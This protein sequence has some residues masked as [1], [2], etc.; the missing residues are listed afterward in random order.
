MID[1]KRIILIC[2]S[3]LMSASLSALAKEHDIEL[4]IIEDKLLKS[5]EV[6]PI[7]RQEIFKLRAHEPFDLI[8]YYQEREFIPY[9]ILPDT[10]RKVINRSLPAC[11]KLWLLNMQIDLK[12]YRAERSPQ[13]LK[14]S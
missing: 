2:G 1:H 14:Q 11:R 10:H 13:F 3:T 7:Y 9:T 4:L 12:S 8:Y 6:S 5:S